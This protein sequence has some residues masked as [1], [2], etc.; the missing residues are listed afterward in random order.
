MSPDFGVLQQN[1]ASAE[2]RGREWAVA[3]RKVGRVEEQ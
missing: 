2:Q 3:S 1:V